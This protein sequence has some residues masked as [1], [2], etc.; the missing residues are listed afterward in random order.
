MRQSLPF[1]LVT[2]ILGL[3][4]P[5][6][7]DESPECE[8]STHEECAEEPKKSTGHFL[9]GARVTPDD[10][11]TLGAAVIQDRLFGSDRGLELSSSVSKRRQEF[12]LNYRDPSLFGTGRALELELHDKRVAYENVSTQHTGGSAQLSR[13]L[14]S[15]LGAYL[16]YRFEEASA[17]LSNGPDG[18]DT[19]EESGI[20]GSLRAGLTFNKRYSKRRHLQSD[21][22]VERSSPRLGSD[23]DFVRAGANASMR[24]PLVGPLVLNLSGYLQ[25]VASENISSLPIAERLQHEGHADVRGFGIGRLGGPTGGIIKAT[26]RAELQFPLVSRWR[27][28]GALFY[29]TGLIRDEHRTSMAQSVGGSLILNSPVGPIRLDVAV[30]LD[31]AQSPQFLLNIGGAF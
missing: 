1:A 2:T 6:L 31:G 15:G 14:S 27:L 19:F 12:L 24:Q 3:A 22:F 8:V 25:A 29:D 16:G 23:Y 20:V 26:S 21:L 17:Q 7:A 4:R 18:G 28:A 10:G 30:P 5:A 11:F 9:I 13:N